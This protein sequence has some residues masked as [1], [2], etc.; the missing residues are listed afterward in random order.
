[1]ALVGIGIVAVAAFF[2]F[3]PIVYSPTTI[4]GPLVLKT[5]PTYP[6]WESLSCW[7]FGYGVYY[8]QEVRWVPATN[9]NEFSGTAPDALT[10]QYGN[11]TQFG[12]PPASTSL[13]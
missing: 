4:Y 10:T 7:A 11:A 13:P 8:G 12:C 2:V 5:Y 1:M 6:N 3:A 9:G